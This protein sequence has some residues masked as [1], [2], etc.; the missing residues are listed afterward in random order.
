MPLT[1]SYGQ[2]V[3]YPTLTD[4][5]NAQTLG[6]GIVEALTPKALM[7]FASGVIRGATI[8]KPIQG[9]MT[10]LQDVGRFEYFNGSSWQRLFPQ[11]SAGS[12]SVSFTN[13]NTYTRDI[14]FSK[15]FAATP[16]VTVNI[17][18]SAG[19]TGRWGA[20]AYNVTASGFTLFLYAG[21]LNGTEKATWS[22]QIVQWQAMAVH[23]VSN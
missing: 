1:D 21:D 2:G 22:G 6:Q 16:T 8:K 17:N 20:R 9:M 23:G 12:V 14:T 11:T 15:P 19:S 5:P 18:S 4:K 13:E 10:W 3:Q 7:S